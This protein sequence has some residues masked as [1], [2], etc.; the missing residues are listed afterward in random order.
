MLV[1]LP[2]SSRAAPIAH[3]TSKPRIFA[4]RAAGSESVITEEAS[5]AKVESAAAG[6]PV[7][8]HDF[9]PLKTKIPACFQSANSC[10]TQTRNC[11]GH[12][13]CVNKYVP[14]PDP[15][16]E[17]RADDDGEGPAVCFFCHCASTLDRP[18]G[19]GIGISTTHWAGNMCQKRDI[20]AP[21]WM[22]TIFSV[23]II[24]ALTFAIGML[25]SVGEE[26]LPGV[27]GAGVS[28]AK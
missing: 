14:L 20:S 7:D 17:K 11:S 24:G 25:F 28:K 13:R 26:K 12:G 21:F 27:I 22:I 18:E 10:M 16:N 15:D 23:S 8:T 6:L 19:E 4:R 3:W 5:V 2:E 1:L 9:V